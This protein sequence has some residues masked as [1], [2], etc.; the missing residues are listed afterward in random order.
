[1]TGF[2]IN[3]TIPLLQHARIQEGDS[4]ALQAPIFLI[5]KTGIKLWASKGSHKNKNPLISEVFISNFLL[6]LISNFLPL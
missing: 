3:P 4:V 1:M 2:G 5:W 6:F